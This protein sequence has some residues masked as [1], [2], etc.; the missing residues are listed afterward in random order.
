MWRSQIYPL[1]HHREHSNSYFVETGYCFVTATLVIN[2][3]VY[4]AAV[5]PL[6]ILVLYSVQ[7]F[8]LKTSPQLRLLEYGSPSAVRTLSDLVYR[9]EAFAP[10]L[11]HFMES[12][13]GL[14]TLRGLGWTT[15][16]SVRVIQLL[17]TAQ[18]PYYLLL[19]VQ[20]WLVFILD[21]IVAALAVMVTGLAIALRSWLNAGFLGLALV[22]L[23]S[24]SLS[25]TNL[26]QQWTLLETSLGDIARIKDFCTNTPTENANAEFEV[27][28]T[29][30]PN[31]G[32][33]HLETV[34]ASYRQVST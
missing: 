22:N 11:S 19:C 4:I 34:C 6:L 30:W 14:L 28:S 8:Y 1:R 12:A 13:S 24:I 18:K 21:L 15:S 27:P 3:V 17:D 32:A 7:R 31:R 25:L 2:A 5:L 9:L 16:Y 23:M 33:L 20:Q 10:L 26:V 29:S